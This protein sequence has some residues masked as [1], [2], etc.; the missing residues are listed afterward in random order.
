MTFQD[1]F[2][3]F[4]QNRHFAEQFN[5]ANNVLCFENFLWAYTVYDTLFKEGNIIPVP[6]LYSPVFYHPNKYIDQRIKPDDSIHFQLVFK[7]N[8]QRVDVQNNYLAT[9]GNDELMLRY[10]AF[11]DDV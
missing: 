7:T 1:F 4:S 2:N 5:V 9:L 10:G 11:F 3:T 6:G 8:E